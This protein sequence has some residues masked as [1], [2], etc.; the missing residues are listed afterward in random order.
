MKSIFVFLILSSFSWVGFAAPC[1]ARQELSA[2]GPGIVS[3]VHVEDGQ[4][5]KRGEKLI[6]FDSRLLRA[7]VKEAEGAFEAARAYED[8]G[9]DTLTRLQ[10]L[11]PGE[12][13]SEQQLVE[14]RIKLS[15][16]RAVRKQAEG[17]L[18]RMRVQLE[19]ATLKAEISGK[20]RGVPGSIGMAVQAGQSLGRVEAPP[21]FCKPKNIKN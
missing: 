5:V 4:D 14:S 16:A 9:L 13:V 18:D 17:A 3:R 12:A 11:A 19:D 15:Q 6:E 10:K 8:L 21:D 1:I 2:K 7:T 20:V